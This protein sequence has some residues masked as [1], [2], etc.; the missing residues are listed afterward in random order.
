MKS[1]STASVD[2]SDVKQ[3]I[4]FTVGEEEFGLELQRVKEV[5]RMC[6]ITWLPRA[7]YYMKGVISLRGEVIPIINL[8]ERLGLPA[9]RQTSS[10]RIIVVELK[11]R[12]VGIVVDSASQVVRLPGEQIDPAPQAM[13]KVAE[14]LISGIG[15]LD[16]RLI[17][18]LDIDSVV[19]S[20][21]LVRISDSLKDA[22]GES[23]GGVDLS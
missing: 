1:L 21:E 23:S 17:V 13:S 5:I 22:A 9:I 7:P 10:T 14:E 6:Q 15:K 19:T 8:R 16:E 12:K 2:A 20:E 11:G 4:S 18:L 3:L